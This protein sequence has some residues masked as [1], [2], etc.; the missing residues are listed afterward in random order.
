MVIQKN[1]AD[2]NPKIDSLVDTHTSDRK[3]GKI[4]DTDTNKGNSPHKL[5]TNR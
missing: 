2:S 4:T 5:F 1:V 3:K